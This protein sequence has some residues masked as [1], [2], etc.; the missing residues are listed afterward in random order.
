MGRGKKLD[1]QTFK[2]KVEERFID[3]ENLDFTNIIYVNAKTKV[4]F[5]CKMHGSITVDPGELLRSAGCPKCSNNAK[6]PLN[7]TNSINIILKLSTIIIHSM[8][9]IGILFLDFFGKC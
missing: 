6:K 2:E 1:T 3:N 5:E 8:M 7:I 9:I 4:T